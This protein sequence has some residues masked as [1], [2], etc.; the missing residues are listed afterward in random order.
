MHSYVLRIHAAN[1]ELRYVQ[2]EQQKHWEQIHVQAFI[3]KLWGWLHESVIS[4]QLH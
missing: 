1:H 4:I 2:H 3:P